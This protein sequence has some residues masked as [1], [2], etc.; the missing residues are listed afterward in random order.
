VKKP[1]A[2]ELI[3]FIDLTTLQGDDNYRSVETLCRKLTDL[4]D[5]FPE[6]RLPATLCVLPVFVGLV[7]KWFHEFHLDV[8][9]ATVAGDFPLG[10]LPKFL[11]MEQVRYALDEG[12]DEIDFTVSRRLLLEGNFGEYSDEISLASEMCRHKTLKII[13]ET[14]ELRDEVLIKKAANL[15]VKSGAHFLKTSTGKSTVH[16]TPTAVRILCEVARDYFL[17]T[18][19]KIG[20]KPS[21]GIRTFEDAQNFALIAAQI[22]GKDWLQPAYFRIGTSSLLDNLIPKLN[23]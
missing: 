22:C 6:I 20:I 8:K 1:D 12:A 7:R 14:G 11:K 21:G 9:V 18:G 19:K 17:S 3:S 16:A 15:A 5:K 23:V 10:Q 4:R 13:L 2:A